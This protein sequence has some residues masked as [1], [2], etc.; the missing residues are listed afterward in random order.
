MAYET[1]KYRNREEAAEA[2][3]KMMQRKREWV[4]KTEREFEVLA[5][6]RTTNA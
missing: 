4:E 6:L 5:K 1:V 3:R 2:L